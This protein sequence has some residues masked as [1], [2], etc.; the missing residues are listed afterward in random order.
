[1]HVFYLTRYNASVDAG[2]AIIVNPNVAALHLQSWH[3]MLP[4]I[5]YF[6]PKPREAQ[7][8]KLS[9]Q[10]FPQIHNPIITTINT[11]INTS[12]SGLPWPSIQSAT[13]NRTPNPTPQN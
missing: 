11:T 6:T 1:M 7:V 3:G 13:K 12:P 8:Q 9:A 2:K 5:F 10:R 4:Y